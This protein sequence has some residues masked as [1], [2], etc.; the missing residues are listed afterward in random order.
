LLAWLNGMARQKDR[1]PLA[2]L[3][4]LGCQVSSV[5]VLDS[6]YRE[7]TD[8]RS[9]PEGYLCIFFRCPS[10]Y[11]EILKSGL[12]RP[13]LVSKRNVVYAAILLPEDHDLELDWF[14][15][16]SQQ[17]EAQEER[18]HDHSRTVSL[19]LVT[20]VMDVPPRGGGGSGVGGGGGGGF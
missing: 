2:N 18:T 7:K 3:A 13:G 12:P 6:F 19:S 11:E 17:A 1:A 8:C 14:F 15:F 4:L 9:S 16:L 10:S 5:K 20:A